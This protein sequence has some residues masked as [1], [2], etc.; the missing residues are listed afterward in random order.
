MYFAWLLEN[1]RC[2]RT[3]DYVKGVF[4]AVLGKTLIVC[5]LNR[6]FMINAFKVIAASVV[7]NFV[8]VLQGQTSDA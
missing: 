8:E 3:V 4:T 7:W 6:G 2:E 1:S 5:H